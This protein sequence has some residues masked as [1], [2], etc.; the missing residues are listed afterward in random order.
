MNNSQKGFIGIILVIILA[1][2]IVG[3][4]AY[5]YTTQKEKIKTTSEQTT[6]TSTTSNSVTTSPTVIADVEE[7][8]NGLSLTDAQFTS[9]I[10]D[11]PQAKVLARG[12]VNMD[13]FEDAIVQEVHCGASCSISLQVVLNM[14]NKTAKLLKDKNYPDTFAPAFVGSSA[15]KSQVDNISIDAKGII[16]L[17]GNGLDCL[18]FT[19]KDDEDDPCTQEKWSIR[20]TATYKFD[21]KNIV[22]LSITPLPATSSLP[23]ILKG[24]YD[25]GESTNAAGFAPQIWQ[26]TLNIKNDGGVGPITLNV[27]GHMMLTRINAHGVLG[28]EGEIDIVFDSYGPEN[29]YNEYKKGDVLFS[30]SPSRTNPVI[31]W[32]R[33]LPQLDSS[34]EGSTFVKISS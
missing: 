16:S 11:D 9:V 3:G 13:G 21:G 30:L 17:T 32:K 14:Q 20:R 15:A 18:H 12:D 24:T 5:I 33:M 4:G 26:Y 23:K 7:K 6:A 34:I 22:Q 28:K 8:N 1:L 2:G 19:L 27:D 10:V 29:M 31:H 25:F